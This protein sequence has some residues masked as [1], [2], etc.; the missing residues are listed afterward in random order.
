MIPFV[1][2][3]VFLLLMISMVVSCGSPRQED[4]P[5]NALSPELID[6]PSTASGNDYGKAIPVISYDKTEHDFGSVV[7][8]EKVSFSFHFTNSGKSD[9][10]I[11]H[12][13][14]SCGC[15]VPEWPKDPIPPGKDGYIAVTFDSKGRLGM[16]HKTVTII[17][18]TI[19]NTSTLT[20]TGEVKSN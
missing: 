2:R 18:N 4:V 9:L 17:A 5:E 12:A 16:V 1:M 13:Q 11:R 19:P 10:L 20:I 15:T 3:I 8:G 14:A 7:D 6:N